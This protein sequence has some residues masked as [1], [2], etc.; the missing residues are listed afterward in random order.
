MKI[1]RPAISLLASVARALLVAPVF[2]LC[3][4]QCFA[5][6]VH[7]RV[8]QRVDPLG[9]DSAAPTL[10]WQ[11]DST[12]RNWTQ[13]AYRILVASSPAALRAEHADVWDSGK[14]TSS[15]SVNVEYAGPA[16]KSHQRCYWAVHTWDAKGK[17]E[18]STE[19]AWWE[20]GLLQPP[21]WQAQWIRRSNDDETAVLKNI[22]WIWLPEGDAQHVPQ[23]AE[24]E[25]R[26]NL[27]LSKVP[28]SASLHVFAGGIFTTR[29][30]SVVTGHKDQWGSFDR[31]DIR[32]QLHAGDNQIVVHIETPK[33]NDANKTFRAA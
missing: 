31:E 3:V 21:D 11:S 13:S 23:G 25:F 14:Q 18:R 15:E 16:L 8:D 5:A 29:V 9:I 32:D 6:P 1:L 10:S 7:L 33:A 2:S 27:H 26:Y 24:A 12:D 30:N 28:A 17:E 20:M 4:A 22:S 19:A